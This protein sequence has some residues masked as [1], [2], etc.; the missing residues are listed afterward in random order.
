MAALLV[1]HDV[2]ATGRSPLPDGPEV[3]GPA[4]LSPPRMAGPPMPPGCY[5]DVETQAWVEY[6]KSVGAGSK[7][8]QEDL[9]FWQK[10]GRVY[11]NTRSAGLAKNAAMAAGPPTIEATGLVI[12]IVAHPPD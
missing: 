3:D 5:W 1:D 4:Q 11:K 9:S 6:D 10:V 7:P 2:G 12:L 8:A